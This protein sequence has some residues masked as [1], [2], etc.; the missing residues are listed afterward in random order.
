MSDFKFKPEKD[1]DLTTLLKEGE[2]QYQ[3]I[4]A[5]KKESKNGNPMI[6]LLLKCWDCEGNQGNIFEYL[7]LNDNVFSKR[8][9]KHFC[10]SCGLE[11]KYESGELNA[12][13]CENKYG[14]LIIGIQKDKA[15]QYPDKN[16]VYDFLKPK[17][18]IKLKGKISPEL[19]DDI[20]F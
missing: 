5:E 17:E 10:Y 4:K 19:N 9:I 18:D 14:I 11:E 2:G 1:E 13:D 15:G 6:K 8:K 3:V 12:S 20:P 16:S 7:I